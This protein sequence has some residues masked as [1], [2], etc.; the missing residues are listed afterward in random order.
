MSTEETRPLPENPVLLVDGDILLYRCG[1]AGEKTKYLVEAIVAEPVYNPEGGLIDGA[2]HLSHSFYPFESKKEADEFTKTIPEQVESTIWSRRELDKLENVLHSAKAILESFVT[3][4]SPSEVRIYL[5]GR[6]N[7]RDDIAFTKEY[8]GNRIQDKPKYFKDI[9][10]YLINVHGASLTEGIEADD[11]IGI[12]AQSLGARSI[13]VTIDKDLDQV[14]GWHY[15][16]V[17]DKLYWIDQRTAQFNL[18][19][20]ILSGDPTDNVPGLEGIGGAKAARLLAGAE[21]HLDLHRRTWGEYMRRYPD[22]EFARRYFL[23]QAN[24][25]YILREAGKH[26]EPAEPI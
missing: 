13:T 16:W 24:L 23:E 2:A 18:Y 22:G 14:A 15:N 20:Q 25:V 26:F 7:F 17:Q 12:D 1:W 5:S 21:S 3:K 8:K 11:A 4:F 19:T 9:K 10:D 6:K